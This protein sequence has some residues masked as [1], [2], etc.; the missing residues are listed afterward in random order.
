MRQPIA[1]RRHWAS[2]TESDRSSQRERPTARQRGCSRAR[3]PSAGAA[4]S[5]MRQHSFGRCFAPRVALG[6]SLPLGEGKRNSLAI[7]TSSVGS[8]AICLGSASTRSTPFGGC[9]RGGDGWRERPGGGS[10][11]RSPGGPRRSCRRRRR[12]ERG[13]SG[14][15]RRGGMGGLV[16]WELALSLTVAITLGVPAAV[17]TLSRRLRRLACS[18]WC[19]RQRSVVPLQL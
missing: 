18:L 8:V 2:S 14:W 4:R 7:A 3:N 9:A 13:R 15:H 12:A 5:P 10:R 11:R 17:D 16:A 19:G 6:G 1:S